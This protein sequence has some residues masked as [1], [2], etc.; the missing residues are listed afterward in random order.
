[1]NGNNTSGGA[2]NWGLTTTAILTGKL[3]TGSQTTMPASFAA[4]GGKNNAPIPFI[5]GVS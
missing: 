1:M 4:G 3:T 2:V 5:V